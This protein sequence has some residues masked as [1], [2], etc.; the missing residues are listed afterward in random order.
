[1]HWSLNIRGL[2]YEWHNPRFNPILNYFN[3]TEGNGVNFRANVNCFQWIF[4]RACTWAL[5][6]A[7]L[8]WVQCHFMVDSIPV[9]QNK[10]RLKN[11]TQVVKPQKHKSDQ[12][13][14][15][16]VGET[17]V[18]GRVSISQI[19]GWMF[20]LQNNCFFC[21]FYFYYVLSSSLQ[22]PILC[23]FLSFLYTGV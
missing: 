8:D 12:T 3:I 4:L 11:L 6:F 5:I 13:Y 7:Q 23:L 18:P 16:A 15:F 2:I 19:L 1:M 9:S 22:W 20:S 14:I 10:P 21:N 17:L